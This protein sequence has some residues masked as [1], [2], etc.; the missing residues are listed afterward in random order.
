MNE[1]RKAIR[2]FIC[3]NT[4]F[5]KIVSLHRSI[6]KAATEAL[7]RGISLA[8]LTLNAPLPWC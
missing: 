4:Q 3:L 8:N 6:R 7:V 2:D 5:A 1:A